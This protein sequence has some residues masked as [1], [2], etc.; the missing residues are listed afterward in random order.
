[1]MPAALRARMA[2]ALLAWYACHG[3]RT[4]PWRVVRDPYR[5]L[6]S[7][8]MLQ[9]TQVERVVSAFERF[10]A[11]FPDLRSLAAAPTAEVIRAWQGLG[12]NARAVRLKRVAEIAVERYGGAIPDDEA[13]LRALPGIGPYTAAAILAFAYDRPV[14]AVDVNLR[15][16]IHRLIFGAEYPPAVSAARLDAIAGELVS[17]RRAHDWNSAMMDLGATICT[18]RAPRCMICPL[19]RLCAAVPLDATRLD[20]LRA[21]YGRRAAR[22]RFEHSARYLRGRI[23]DRLR[24]LPDGA[25][26]SLLDLHR[27]LCD[28]VPRRT[29]EEFG[30]MVEA[31]E[32]D[33][34]VA[35]NGDLVRLRE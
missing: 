2:R 26:V 25:T 35:R 12:Y 5:T 7:E 32:R 33:G 19:R 3:R 23:V 13:A 4:L 29:P 18:A 22:E 17:R 31:L 6:V 15:R 11:R 8:F 1:M 21:R 14:A 30:E 9:Q 28:L 20:A 27:E 34:L 10:V 16:V 24:A